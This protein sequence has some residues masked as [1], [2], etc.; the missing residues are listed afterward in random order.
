MERGVL[1][2]SS[3]FVPVCVEFSCK[4]IKFENRIF[5]KIKT[6]NE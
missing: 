3:F 5:T 4:S 2:D 6:N 1:K